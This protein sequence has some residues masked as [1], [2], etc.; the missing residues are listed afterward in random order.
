MTIIQ[1]L[2]ESKKH[3]HLY[4]YLC[5]RH[6]YFHSITKEELIQ[7]FFDSF[8]YRYKCITMRFELWIILEEL[9]TR[10]KLEESWKE[11]KK[12]FCAGN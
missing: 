8:K 3:P 2:E 6:S 4:E 11:I 1:V 12:T 7:L 9:K 5:R 10:K